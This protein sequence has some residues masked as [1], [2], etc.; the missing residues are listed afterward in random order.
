MDIPSSSMGNPLIFFR[1]TDR[2]KLTQALVVDPVYLQHSHS[3]S[4]IDYRVQYISIQFNIDTF[5]EF[6]LASFYQLL[7]LGHSTKQEV[8]C[9]KAVVCHSELWD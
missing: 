1:V 2:S 4:V 6:K 5:V 9:I 7:A 8:S 3:E